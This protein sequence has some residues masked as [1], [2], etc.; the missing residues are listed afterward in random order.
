VARA[1]YVPFSY[2]FS[3][4]NPTSPVFPGSPSAL[5]T[6]NSNTVNAPGMS[7]QPSK[8]QLSNEPS[9]SEAASTDIVA[10]NISVT[11]NAVRNNEDH[12]FDGGSSLT[13]NGGFA[14][15]LNIKDIASG[16]ETGLDFH[17]RFVGTLSSTS[18]NLDVMWDADYTKDNAIVFTLGNSEYSVYFRSYAPPGPPTAGLKGSITF[19]VD[20]R[21]LD[22]QK[23]PEPSTMVLSCVSLTLMG[24]AG[25]RK[26]RQMKL[27]AE[28][29]AA[30]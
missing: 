3:P 5:P 19:H 8:I 11:S 17:G 26:R 29:Q 10:T 18:S 14:L 1:D 27:Q 20:A 16:D 22:L 4:I 15:R 25:W 12:F 13:S 2:N 28:Q 6:L 7:P 23:A 24:I 21:P 9:V 30:I